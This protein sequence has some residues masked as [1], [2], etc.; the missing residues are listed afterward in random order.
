M[1]N[2]GG[3]K[4]TQHDAKRMVL[5]V[6][7]NFPVEAPIG[8]LTCL[9]LANGAIQLYVHL[10]SGRWDKLQT[11]ESTVIAMNSDFPNKPK[12]G[13]LFYNNRAEEEEVPDNEQQYGFYYV[14][15]RGQFVRLLDV[16]HEQHSDPHPQYIQVDE[17][18]SRF[19][20]LKISQ[21]VSGKT[22][23][24]LL[25]NEF[26]PM[27]A[28]DKPMAIPAGMYK[29]E[30]L[31]LIE[32]FGVML[33]LQSNFGFKCSQFLVS[34]SENAIH[35]WGYVKIEQDT[36]IVPNFKIRTFPNSTAKPSAVHILPGSHISFDLMY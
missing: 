33:D 21:E 36:N 4:P 13:S 6:K 15:D 29:F 17:C 23:T 11:V 30:C 10:G 7:D 27:K 35:T 19:Q 2:F 16:D 34:Q 9:K 12:I 28:L 26:W 1:K 14:S 31:I 20:P 22:Q 32:E 5:D 25:P 24:K 3:S 18:V 8:E